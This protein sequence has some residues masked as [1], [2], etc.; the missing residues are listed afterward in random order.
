MPVY[1]NVSQPAGCL[2]KFIQYVDA[3]KNFEQLG[4]GKANNTIRSLLGSQM[5]C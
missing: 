2:S 1:T 5:H 3:E 4:C